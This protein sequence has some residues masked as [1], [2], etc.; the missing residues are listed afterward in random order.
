MDEFKNNKDGK[1]E[2]LKASIATQKSAL[3]KHAVHVKTQQKELQTSTLEL[4]QIESDIL[5]EKTQLEE[6]K[7]GIAGL[8][9]ELAKLQAKVDLSEA[10]HAKAEEKLQEEMATLSR[11]D[12]EL[13]ELERVIKEQKGIVAQADLGVQDAE[14]KI[15]ALT[16]EQTK[17]QNL[18]EKLEQL[19]PWIEEE[20]GSFGKP[21]T[22]YT[23]RGEALT[24]LKLRAD[25]LKNSQE[26]LKKKINPK[27]MN[28]I[29]R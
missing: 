10:E 3:Q 15:Q 22:Q 20:K 9:K 14:H 2:E 23:V 11:F 7:A 24:P 1:I 6:A 13:K 12:T 17:A 21:G 25:E 19:C 8:H 26:G 18:V 4:E 27:V 28:M 29:D 5:G 16:L